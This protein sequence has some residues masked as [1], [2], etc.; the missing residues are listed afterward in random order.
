MKALR[1][2]WQQHPEAEVPP[3]AWSKEV[4]RANRTNFGEVRQMY[5]AAD[6]VGRFLVY[7]LGGNK[8]RLVAE[9]DYQGRKVFVRGIYT[10]K[11]S[12]KLNLK[13]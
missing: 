10:H 12:D 13:G 2:F 3:R 6:L 5:P 1:E 8:F 4:R 9:L 7:N 11:Q